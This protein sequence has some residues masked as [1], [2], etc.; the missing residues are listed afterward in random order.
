VQVHADLIAAI[1]DQDT[2]QIQKLLALHRQDTIR[3]T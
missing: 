2:T 1:K 3:I